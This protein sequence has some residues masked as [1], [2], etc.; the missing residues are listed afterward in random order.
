MISPRTLESTERWLTNDTFW[1][2][3]Y[4][5]PENNCSS[6]PFTEETFMKFPLSNQND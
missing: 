5:D 2:N 4:A 6:T 1:R 3:I